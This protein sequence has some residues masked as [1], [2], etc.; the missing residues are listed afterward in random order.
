[1]A[2]SVLRLWDGRAQLL[3]G[4]EGMPQTL[5]HL[6]AFRRNVIATRGD[7]GDVIEDLQLT[8]LEGW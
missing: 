2:E 8:E 1:V 7:D 4:L 3:K 5:C 6:D